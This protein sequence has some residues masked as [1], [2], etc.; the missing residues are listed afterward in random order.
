MNN[1]TVDL[2][3]DNSNFLYVN[4]SWRDSRYAFILAHIEAISVPLANTVQSS[5]YEMR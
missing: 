4:Y 5:A 3:A 2:L 1:V